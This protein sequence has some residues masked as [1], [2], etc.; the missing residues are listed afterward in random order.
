MTTKSNIFYFSAPDMYM[1]WSESKV[2]MLY[3]ENLKG[4]L[5]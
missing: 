5:L 1:M 3:Y 4:R 2:N